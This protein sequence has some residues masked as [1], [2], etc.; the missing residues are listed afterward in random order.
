[1]TGNVGIPGG[2][3][4]G[5]EGYYWPITKWFDNGENP[6]KAAISCFG[7]T[8]A[9][10][11]GEEMTATRDGVRGVEEIDTGISSSTLPTTPGSQRGY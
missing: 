11:H 8:D 9:I 7:W 3:T 4:G 6:C 5:R 1:M 2:G 10:D